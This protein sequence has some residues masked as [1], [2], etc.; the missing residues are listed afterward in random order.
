VNALMLDDPGL[1]ATRPAATPV[2]PFNADNTVSS[3]DS[4]FSVLDQRGFTVGKKLWTAEVVG[5]HIVGLDTWI[6]LEFSGDRQRSLLLRVGPGTGVGAAIDA[7]HA[8]LLRR[9]E[10]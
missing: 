3:A 8:T 7:I 10:D 4:W 9:S 6:Q 2:W 5:V 1:V